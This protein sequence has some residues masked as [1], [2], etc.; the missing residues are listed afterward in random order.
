MTIMV[1]FKN[2]VSMHKFTRFF[3]QHLR[4]FIHH[5]FKSGYCKINPIL[6]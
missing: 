1:L 4:H 6:H 3:I 2:T 5:I